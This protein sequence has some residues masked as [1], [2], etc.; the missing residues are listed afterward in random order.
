MMGEVRVKAILTNAGDEVLVRRGLLAKEQ[1]RRYEADALVDTGA[2]TP[3]LPSFVVQ[4]LG[5]QIIGQ[6]NA[7]WGDS[8]VISVDVAEVVKIDINGRT[9]TLEPLVTGNEVLLGQMVLEVIDMQVDCLNQRL[10]P[11]PAHPDQPVLKLK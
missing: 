2:V 6:R 3:V 7:E 11:N 5:L 10:I 9:V 8:S 1:V 4:Q